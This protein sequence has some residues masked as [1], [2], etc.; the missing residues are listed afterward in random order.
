MLNFS[1]PNLIAS[2]VFGVF[3]W[4]IFRNAKSEGDGRRILAGLTLM[5]YGLFVPNPWLNW[6]IGSALLAFTYYR[7]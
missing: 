2:F 6:A 1:L 3:G 4:F 7:L 5:S